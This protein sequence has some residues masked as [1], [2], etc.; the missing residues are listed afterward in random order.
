MKIF[1]STF[2]PFVLEV[3][4]W[5]VSTGIIFYDSANKILS[6]S[7][8]IISMVIYFILAYL[9][10]ARKPLQILVSMQN[11]I[12]GEKFTQFN[13]QSN[14]KEIDRTVSIIIEVTKTNSVFS[15]IYKKILNN[16]NCELLF[17][18][19]PINYFVLCP[20]E[21]LLIK[22]DTHGFFID[23]TSIIREFLKEDSIKIERTF[24]FVIF[25]SKEI[26]ANNNI[27]INI[28][29]VYLVD[30]KKISMFHSLF[31]DIQAERHVIKYLDGYMGI[32]RPL[33]GVNTCRMPREY[34]VGS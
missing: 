4:K 19:S 28:N 33:K 13:A 20:E 5:I 11:K 3:I 12:S 25:S 30:G 18:T 2:Y 22:L 6:A 9:F 17:N 7:S 8:V 1:K 29:P 31:Y 15:G 23:I 24:E 16:S 21:T 10:K 32:K 26:D 14:P 27:T 34:S